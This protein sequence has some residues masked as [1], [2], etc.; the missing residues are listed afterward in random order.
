MYKF[1]SKQMSISDFGMPL[2]ITL[3][4]DNRWAKK[5]DTIPWDEIEIRYAALFKNKKGNVAKPLRL[6]LG[7]L[8]IQTEYQY[9]D[10]EVPLQIQETPCLQFFCGLPEYQD[11][12]PFDSSLMVYFRKRLTPE[13][14]G[15]INEMSGINT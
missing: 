6:A 10:T 14:F 13:I 7:A 8:I 11:K 4:P 15:E 3:S 9:P 5:A 12:P 2:G 1:L